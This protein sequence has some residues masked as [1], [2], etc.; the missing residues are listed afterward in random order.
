MTLRKIMFAAV[1]LTAFGLVAG[2]WD[3]A[4]PQLPM[5]PPLPAPA[6]MPMPAVAPVPLPA[7]FPIPTPVAM[8]AAL[9][10]E[11]TPTEQQ[12]LE[13][14]YTAEAAV[15]INDTNAAAAADALAQEIEAELATE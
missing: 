15:E 11:L 3:D 7:P 2:C 5:Q 9:G 12:T 8:P 10:Q 13:V 6:P 1:L 4:P 14:Q